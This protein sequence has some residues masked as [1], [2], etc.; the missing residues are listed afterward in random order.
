MEKFKDKLKLRT[1]AA[2]EGS[3]SILTPGGGG[4][5]RTMKGG[6]QGKRLLS[7]SAVNRWL[8]VN[9]QDVSK[10][11]DAVH[12]LLDEGADSFGKRAELMYARR[13]DILQQVDLLQSRYLTLAARY[14]QLFVTSTH[15]AAAA[16][17]ATANAA[18]GEDGQADLLSPMISPSASSAKLAEDAAAAEGGMKERGGGRFDLGQDPD[19]IGFFLGQ[20]LGSLGKGFEEEDGQS[21]WKELVEALSKLRSVGEENGEES[22][23]EENREEEVADVS[24]IA[25]AREAVGRAKEQLDALLRRVKS[26]AEEEEAL[27]QKLVSLE[28]LEEENAMLREIVEG[29]A[30]TGAGGGGGADGAAG[31]GGAGAGAGAGGNGKAGMRDDERHVA[32]EVEVGQLRIR[33]MDLKLKLDRLTAALKESREREAQAA[34]A[35]EKLKDEWGKAEEAGGGGEEEGAE[36][37]GGDGGSEQEKGGEAEKGE[38]EKAEGEKDGKETEEVAREVEAGQWRIKQMDLQVTI[39]KLREELKAS[40]EEVAQLKA[41][42]QQDSQ[43]GGGRQDMEE[44]RVGGGLGSDLASPTGSDVSVASSAGASDAAAAAAAAAASASASALPPTPGAAIPAPSTPGG[45]ALTRV[46]SGSGGKRMWVMGG[47]MMPAI[48]ASAGGA[49]A[50]ASS[51]SREEESRAVAKEKDQYTVGLEVEVGQLKIKNGDLKMKVD[52][53]LKETKELQ[54]QFGAAQEELEV[55][56]RDGVLKGVVAEKEEEIEALKREVEE[57]KRQASGA[58]ERREQAESVVALDVEMGKL[59][60]KN[61]DL[62]SKVEKLQQQVREQKQQLAGLGQGGASRGD[63]GETGDAGSAGGGGGSSEKGRAVSR[64]Y[65][66]KGGAGG[67]GGG[68]N[69]AGGAA[70]EVAKLQ[71]Q[72]RDC[73]RAKALVEEE[74]KRKDERIKQLE[75]EVRSKGVE[76]GMLKRNMQRV[77]G[78]LKDLGAASGKKEAG[79]GKWGAVGKVTTAVAAATAIAGAGGG[80]GTAA[81]AASMDGDNVVVHDKA[82]DDEAAGPAVESEQ[83]L[84]KGGKS[85]SGN[86]SGS[87]DEGRLVA[88]EEEVQQLRT[89]LKAATQKVQVLQPMAALNEK[90]VKK[91]QVLEEEKRTLQELLEQVLERRRRRST[92]GGGGGGGGERA[93]VSAEEERRRQELVQRLR[94]KGLVV[95]DVDDLGDDDYGDGPGMGFGLFSCLFQS[96]GMARLMH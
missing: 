77:E 31:G 14:E 56:K 66:W 18:A 64:S 43:E 11:A 67:G 89:A 49:G 48:E 1:A 10:C 80:G 62:K 37:V 63:A 19:A 28:S 34:I 44:R 24:T 25:L 91:L 6:D 45:R 40:K 32:L 38:E 35:L 50:G 33:N 26:A 3:G 22:K 20:I 79:R 71:A 60:M 5:A 47:R 30:E 61:M 17:A 54:E 27:K 68:D 93:V 95:D 42:Q 88:L 84:G 51:E 29:E 46:P 12:K 85:G 86:G 65:S 76:M 92:G 15:Y 52:K 8:K 39:K 23:E 73:E 9:T 75:S 83:V 69:S 81:R 53:L 90:L 82:G 16:A 87:V 57:G 94:E 72:V 13:P 70:G 55:W 4:G 96:R 58:A 36:G 41:L 59:R 21:A 74:G 7:Q 2:G 78:E